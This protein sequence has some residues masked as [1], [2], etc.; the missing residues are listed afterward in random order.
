MYRAIA[1]LCLFIGLTGCMTLPP[2][3]GQTSSA[4]FVGDSGSV[5]VTEVVVSVPLDEK[6]DQFRNLHVPFSAIINARKISSADRYDVEAIIRRSRTRLS[7]RIV[8][9]VNAR[10]VVTVKDLPELRKV[11]VADAQSAFDSVFSKWTRADVFTVDIV[12]T[13]IFFTDGSVGR[14]ER[15]GRFWW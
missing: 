4:S 10:G 14:N 7:S 11:L 1:M 15:A 13:S 6:S 3:Q 12:I 8:A 5:H 9:D 2:P